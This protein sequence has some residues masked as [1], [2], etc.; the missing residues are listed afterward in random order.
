MSEQSPFQNRMSTY[1]A[2]MP[3]DD[4][5]VATQANFVPMATLCS[6]SLTT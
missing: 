5:T 6:V 2:R 4:T 3:S 1:G